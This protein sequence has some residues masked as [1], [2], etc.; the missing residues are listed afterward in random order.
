MKRSLTVLFALLLAGCKQGTDFGATLS[1]EE[2]A[3]STTLRIDATT[4]E[5]AVVTLGRVLFYERQLS[6][7]GT[8]SC[9]SCH[10]QSDGF[11]DGSRLSKGVGG[12]LTARH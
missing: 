2:D 5:D 1:L 4:S 11:S 8:I 7:D 3:L 10:R 12:A 9:A 6:R